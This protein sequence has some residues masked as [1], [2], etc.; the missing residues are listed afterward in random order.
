M[1]KK[2]IF[3]SVLVVSLM[4]CSFFSIL[5]LNIKENKITLFAYPNYSISDDYINEQN[6]IVLNKVKQLQ[7][8]A[9]N[10]IDENNLSLSVT[11]LCLQYIRKDRY[12][13]SVWNM[14]LGNIDEN[15]IT[16]VTSQE[17][18]PIF[19]T[20]EILVDKILK[21]EID[22]I[23][24]MAT[25]NAYV[26]YGDTVKMGF[27]SASTDYAGWAGDLMTLLEEVIN[28]RLKNQITDLNALQEYSNSLLGTNSASSFSSSDALADLDALNLYKD[29]T[30]D[31]NLDLY[32]TLL[33]YYSI[34]TSSSN[35]TNRFESA[36]NTLGN[37][38]EIIKSNAVNL[39]NNTMIR[40][41]LI[42]NVSNDITQTDIDIVSQSFANYILEKPYFKFETNT[43]NI[44]YGEEDISIKFIESHINKLKIGITPYIANIEIKE[45]NLLIKPISTGNANIQ[46]FNEENNILDTYLLNIKEVP[47]TNFKLSKT[48]VILNVGD[49]E[50]ITSIISPENAT[51]KKILWKS[52]DE[53]I[54]TVKNG[55]ITG[56]KPGMT[57]VLAQTDSGNYTSKIKVKVTE[58]KIPINS[59]NISQKEITLN[60]DETKTVEYKILPTNATDKKVIFV[61]SDNKIVS[62]SAEGKIKGLKEGIAD[63]TIKTP[64]GKIYSNIKVKVSKKEEI[65][66]IKII[67]DKIFIKEKE[68]KNLNIE[69]I[70]KT[71]KEPNI[72]WKTS[73]ENIVKVSE[74]GEITANSLGRATITAQISDTKIFTSIPVYVYNESKIETKCLPYI[75]Y[76]EVNNVVIATIKFKNDNC[77]IIKGNSY[78]YSFKNNGTYTFKYE[79][80][81]N[82][83]GTIIAKV[84][85]LSEKSINE[86]QNYTKNILIIFGVL[87]SCFFAGLIIYIKRKNA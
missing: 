15:F 10:Y 67:P 23:H 40:R 21:K 17:N 29:L 31:L 58:E 51:N 78:S 54:A 41:M 39:L 18:V 12:N 53:S 24:M 79:D 55:I 66:E 62:V 46:I 80:E 47:I 50:I 22:F 20:D 45:D 56:I 49:T 59:I 25:L 7:T 68:I 34:N 77:K 48:E 35:S 74:T 76:N 37:N 81:K 64:D 86:K 43:G 26:K 8:L 32:N 36:R 1:E 87:I 4:I 57:N 75:N 11:E 3:L 44:T 19:Q 61:S 83:K 69:T 6:K 30:N 71:L 72:I 13:G 2:N 52:E 85:W 84:D 27:V 70:P 63:I 33:N 60:I 42:P 28:Y 16:Y 5:F 73:N 82:N 14:L 38:E 9:E 65:K